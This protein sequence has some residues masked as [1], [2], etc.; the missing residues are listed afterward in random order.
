MAKHKAA[1]E[2]ERELAAQRAQREAERQALRRLKKTFAVRVEG[3][4]AI[5]RADKVNTTLNN[6]RTCLHLLASVFG[7]GRTS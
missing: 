2:R 6:H 4:A 1:E 7:A 5:S 3:S